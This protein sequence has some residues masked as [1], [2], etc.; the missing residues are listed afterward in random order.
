MG[1]ALQLTANLSLLPS[2]Q[3]LTE[4]KFTLIT[5]HCGLYLVE[6]LFNLRKHILSRRPHDGTQTMRKAGRSIKGVPQ[7]ILSSSR[8]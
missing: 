4:R 3:S 5:I 8:W 2:G 7:I 6:Y 1:I